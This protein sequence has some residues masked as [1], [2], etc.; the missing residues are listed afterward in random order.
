MDETLSLFGQPIIISDKKSNM[1]HTWMSLSSCWAAFWE[2]L[3]LA[4]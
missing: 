4:I 3:E 2:K 1:S